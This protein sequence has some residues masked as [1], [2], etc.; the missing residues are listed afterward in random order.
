MCHVPGTGAQQ[1]T[2][3]GPFLASNLHEL[4]SLAGETGHENQPK[5]KTNTSLDQSHERAKRE[6]WGGEIQKGTCLREH[7]HRRQATP[8]KKQM[9]GPE[10]M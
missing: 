7:G 8:S 9:S 6:A 1:S 4:P 10:H 2:L 3:Q 5:Y